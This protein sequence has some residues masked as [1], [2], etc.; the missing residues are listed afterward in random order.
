[1]PDVQRAAVGIGKH[2]DAGNFHFPQRA[3]Q[4]DGDL[5]AI[6]DQDLSKHAG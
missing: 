4:P 6:G 2:R 1:M 3:D 5:A